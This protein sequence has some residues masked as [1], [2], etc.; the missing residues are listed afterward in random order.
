M[1]RK[2]S[3][4]NS[5]AES[6]HGLGSLYKMCMKWCCT[7][8][9]ELLLET[10]HCFRQ[11]I[12]FMSVHHRASRIQLINRGESQTF[13]VCSH[14]NQSPKNSTGMCKNPLNQK[15]TIIQKCVTQKGHN[16]IQRPIT[17]KDQKS[18]F[19]SQTLDK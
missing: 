2:Q 16:H 19:H 11:H 8:H 14:E 7:I 17:C 18:K 3:P 9:D 10:M 15:V 13:R 5:I 4:A 1:K 6:E 12:F